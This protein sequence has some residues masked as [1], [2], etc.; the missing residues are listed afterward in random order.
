[1]REEVIGFEALMDSLLKCQ[2]GVRWKPSVKNYII[3]GAEDVY[4][5]MTSLESGV[6]KN[7]TPHK[8][9]I[10]S[11]KPRDGLSIPFKD[12]VYQRSI[13]DLALY[14][15]MTK[16]FV[17]GNCAC[18]TEKGT[19]YAR[20]LIKKYLWR[21][22]RNHGLKGYVLQIDIKSYYPTMRH[23]K[24]YQAFR[25]KLDE[26]IYTDIVD[27]L[28][29]QGS[30]GVGFFP[31]SQMVQIAGISLPSR[32]DHIVKEQCHI[33]G[34]IRYM[35]DFWAI[36]ESKKALEACLERITSELNALGFK[37]NTKKT[38]IRP[39]TKGFRFLGFDYHL[40]K[41]GKVIMTLASENV[42][43]ERQKLARMA[44]KVKKGERDKT[45]ADECYRGWK[46]H[47]VKGTSHNLLLK[48]DEYYKSLYE[49]EDY[50]DNKSNRPV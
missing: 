47:A 49:E 39:L 4:K 44:G 34:Y 26:D 48:M 30:G 7:S 9:F 42:K 22:F 35:D 8:I 18:Q 45:K 29:K 31:G 27:I 25:A 14:P 23:D 38:F 12:R 1:M 28:E 41:T 5:Q 50:A 10:P 17:I 6:W 19:D 24:V 3:N 20:A 15:S 46:A 2:K 33:K 11:P 21:H 13:N 16:S 36:H 37:P 43:H 40:T 32:I